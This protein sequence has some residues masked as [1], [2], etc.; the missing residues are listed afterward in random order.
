[1]SVSFG[2]RQATGR[3]MNVD[4]AGEVAP[5]VDAG[6]W[7]KAKAL[8]NAGKA[9]AS[10]VVQA[11]KASAPYVVAG[12]KKAGKAVA[13]AA[14]AEGGK[15]A[16]AGGQAVFAF[17]EYMASSKENAALML[18]DA[19]NKY[20][21]APG[22]E[23]AIVPYTGE[24]EIRQTRTMIDQ[25]RQQ[26]AELRAKVAAE[27]AKMGKGEP[28]KDLNALLTDKTTVEQCRKNLCKMSGKEQLTSLDV[29]RMAL[30]LHPDKHPGE[31]PKYQA[32]FDKYDACRKTMFN[33]DSKAATYQCTK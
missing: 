24:Q 10:S 13:N 25:L 19:V 11:G 1:M 12:G 8:A 23:G 17:L 20:T 32:V 22:Y 3:G 16:V 33:A 14:I 7:A 26:A 30:G 28:N 27:R 2:T 5:D 4:D 9:V 21:P 29:K 6:Y 15:A 18:E 31:A